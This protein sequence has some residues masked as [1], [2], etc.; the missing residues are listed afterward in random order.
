L[1]ALFV[2]KFHGFVNLQA[3]CQ[4]MFSLFL[5]YEECTINS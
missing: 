1:E 2:I 5:I 4:M 3:F